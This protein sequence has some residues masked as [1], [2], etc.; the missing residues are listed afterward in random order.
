MLVPRPKASFIENESTKWSWLKS[1]N[2]VS[3]NWNRI[4]FF[5]GNHLPSDA[6]SSMVIFG[7]WFIYIRWCR[8]WDIDWNR[9]FSLGAMVIDRENGLGSDCIECYA[10]VTWATRW[11]AGFLFLQI[12]LWI[13]LCC[14]RS[15]KSFYSK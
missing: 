13:T 9:S 4:L 7:A 2:V 15:I 10:W 14:N 1:C 11:C 12:T 3:R 8:E 5:R 6:H